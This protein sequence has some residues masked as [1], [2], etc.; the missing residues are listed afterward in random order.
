MLPKICKQC[1]KIFEF[2][3]YKYKNSPYGLMAW[4]N[5]KYC[6]LECE[7]LYNKT[8]H[9]KPYKL[10]ETEHNEKLL[11]INKII[12]GEIVHNT[13]RG[14][15]EDILKGK[16]SYELQMVNKCPLLSK[17]RR[18]DKEKKHILIVALPDDARKKFDEV[19]FYDDVGKLIRV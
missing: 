5:K 10:A 18:W 1:K 4:K 9:K 6:S 7:Q 12:N 17:A 2:E 8:N 14:Y 16:E 11:E 13:G 3:N 19:Y 15:F